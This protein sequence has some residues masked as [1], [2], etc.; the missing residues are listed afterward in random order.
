MRRGT[1]FPAAGGFRRLR[2]PGSIVRA[3]R[4]ERWVRAG[5]GF[6]SR[7]GSEGSIIC[8]LRRQRCLWQRK[9]TYTTGLAP[10]GNAPLLSPAATSPPEGEILAAL[11]FELLMRVKVE[12]QVKFPPPGW[13]RNWIRRGAERPENPVTC[14][15]LGERWC[16]APKGVHF[17]APQARLFGFAAKRHKNFIA[18]RA[19]PPPFEPA[20][21]RQAEPSE[22]SE[23]GPRSGP[24]G[25]ATTLSREAVVAP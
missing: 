21:R 3:L 2:R 7:P 11:Y 23:T 24:I 10:A 17:H 14:F 4:A 12:R 22:P 13:Q 15:P 16:A 8:R 5:I 19:I 1:V 9:P 25:A 18:R 20:C 6:A